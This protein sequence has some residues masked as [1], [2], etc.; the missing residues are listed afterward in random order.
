MP[1]HPISGRRIKEIVSP[2]WLSPYALERAVAVPHY[3]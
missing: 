3:T 2:I 1:D